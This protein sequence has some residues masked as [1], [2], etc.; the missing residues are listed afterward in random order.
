MGCI[1]CGRCFWFR[2]I[3]TYLAHA[4]LAL[5]HLFCVALGG[6]LSPLAPPSASQ[7]RKKEFFGG[8]PH[9]GR[10]AALPAPSLSGRSMH[11]GG[12]RGHPAPRQ[13]R[14]APCTLA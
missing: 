9:P 12:F 4:L 8:T 14:C 1:S 6:P 10:D 11:K 5:F 2:Y 3:T 13:G 7:K